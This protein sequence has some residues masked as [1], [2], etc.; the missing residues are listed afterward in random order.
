MEN[1]LFID[2]EK[3]AI[4]KTKLVKKKVPIQ[5][6]NGQI[7]YG[8]RWVNPNDDKQS[9]VFDSMD[10]EDKD[11][12]RNE[13]LSTNKG[14]KKPPEA[15]NIEPV[16]PKIGIR[17]SEHG[18]SEQE[19]NKYL[20]LDGT[21]DIS[22]LHQGDGKLTESDKSNGY[23][24]LSSTLAY[25]PGTKHE[26][27]RISVDDHITSIFKN[28]TYEGLCNVFSHPDGEFSGKLVSMG[29]GISPSTHYIGCTIDLEWESPDGEYMGNTSRTIHRDKQGS[30]HVYTDLTEI[31]AEHQGKGIAEV[32]QDRTEQYWRYLS[33]GNPVHLSL[34]ANI[35]VG[36][37]AWALKGY[38]FANEKDLDLARESFKKFLD[39]NGMDMSETLQKCGYN[40]IS[41]LKHS[42]QF[43]TLHTG[44]KYQI[45]KLLNPKVK[46][47]GL[48]DDVQSKKKGTLG[49]CFMLGGMPAWDAEKIINGGT[50]HEEIAD[51]FKHL[52]NKKKSKRGVKNG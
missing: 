16:I 34:Q 27:D 9:P 7:H 22:S 35:S 48:D 52:K 10:K 20:G 18:L 8:Y 29:V 32:D 19:L 25:T 46:P 43:A 37:Y 36:V 49:K 13:I 47:V 12:L 40:D 3:G 6:K 21:L 45:K 42:W 4:N 38:D 5:G 2:L 17:H 41:E 26:I 30:L 14:K 44:E 23:S 31:L 15:F 50:E 39:V 33:D 24:V 51:Y 1:L 11:Y 28:T